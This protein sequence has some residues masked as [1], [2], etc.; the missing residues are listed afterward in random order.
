M[1]YAR[2]GI[3]AA[4]IGIFCCAIVSVGC[5][6]KTARDKTRVAS[7]GIGE[8]AL[9]LDRIERDLYGGNVYDKAT[10]DKLG[11]GV[12]KVLYAARGYERAAAGWAPGGPAPDVVD[13]A[14]KG[15]LDAL[16]DFE[17]LIPQLAPARDPL[18]R[19]LNAIRAAVASPQA[20]LK[21]PTVVQAQAAPL[22]DF[23]AIIQVLG[24]LLASGRTT[25][26]RIREL[27]KKEGATDLELGEM[28][29][30][31]TAAIDARERDQAAGG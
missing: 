26:E 17:K 30:R 24:S 27:L 1:R 28:D 12:L 10:H 18:I 21:L 13:Q 2:I 5:A 15:V 8:V 3:A 16:A 31:L 14:R 11:Q 23:L 25:Y 9:G 22:F 20:D 4:A 19:A 6:A 7:L 29:L